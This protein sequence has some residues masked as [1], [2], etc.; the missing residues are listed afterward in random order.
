VSGAPPSISAPSLTMSVPFVGRERE[1]EELRSCYERTRSTGQPSTVLIVG[2]SG[3][4]KSCLVRH[5]TEGAAAQDKD[6][7]LVTGRCYE[8][9][10]V[11][12]KALDGVVDELARILSRLRAA[13]VAP[14]LPTRP[15]PLV[16]MFPVLRRVEAIAQVHAQARAPDD[17]VADVH[18]LRSRAFGAMRELL[19]RIADRRRTIVVIDDLQWADADSLALLQHILR[20]PEGPSVLLVATMRD[21]S[22]EGSGSHGRR[23]PGDGIPGYVRQLRLERLGRDDARALALHL[24][25]RLSPATPVDADT[26]AAEADGH[27][28]FI[29]EIVRHLSLVGGAHGALKLEDALWARIQALE[30]APRRIVEMCAV[31]G[32]PLPLDALAKATRAPAADFARFVSFLRVAHLVRASGT[33]GNDVIECFHGRVR[34]AVVKH[35]NADERRAQSYRLSIALE[36]TGHTDSNLLA[37]LWFGAG[38][39]GKAGEHTLLAADRAGVALAFERA[40]R[41][42]ERALELLT[43]ATPPLPR[44]EERV[45]QTKLGDALSNAGRGAKAARAYRR[46]A[47]GASAA[48]VLDLRWRA[49]D[50]LLRSGHFD[51]GLAAIQEVLASIGM[52]LPSTPWRALLALLFWRVVLAVRGVRHRLV[53]ASAVSARDLVKID[54]CYSIASS[55]SLIDPICAQLF[56]VRNLLVSL[57]IGERKRVARALALEVS[58]Q[59]MGGGPGW[60]R[61]Q[62]LDAEARKVADEVGEPFAIAW[63]RATSSVAHYLVGRFVEALALC[64]EAERA[65]VEQCPGATWETLT[66]RLFAIHALA[67]LGRLR[68]LQARH[69]AALTWALERGD[70]YAAVNLRIGYPNMAWLVA[71]DPERA[72]REATEAMQQWSQRSFQLEH[73][74]ELVA[75][76]NADLYEGRARDAWERISLRRQ[77]LRRSFLTRVQIV[78]LAALNLRAR[79][80]VALAA[81]DPAARSACLAAAERDVRAIDREE[82]AWTAPTSNLVHA[83]ILH[84]RGDDARAIERLERAIGE[85]AAAQLDLVGPGARYALGV[86][87]GGAEGGRLV[88]EAETELARQGAK[89]PRGLLAVVAPGF[90]CFDAV[91]PAAPAT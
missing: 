22:P 72:R 77:A 2:E 54:A 7:L 49:G 52:K 63:S 90:E 85:A 39:L 80:A 44:A 67:Q 59:A 15:A 61:A 11:P 37:L 66:M 35:L 89:M 48:D 45:L 18:E 62:R 23:D 14:L 73:Y 56:H 46:A 29:D 38:E 47:E 20:P 86:C 31:A 64:N 53:D 28:L 1:L 51:E 25:Q 78:R 8:R 42:Y 5:F 21:D 13:D 19:V 10:T 81:A 6:L 57:R 84:L 79:A 50:Q 70:L 34:E 4:G 65:F 55:L 40:A 68:E 75:L 69:E 3:I 71:G 88:A 32:S 36:S 58:Y 27:P 41:L 12:Y 24:V 82:M 16:Q 74:Y 76:T 60:A 17:A 83:A 33:R 91:D 26:L 30:E 43:Q 9:E 87:K